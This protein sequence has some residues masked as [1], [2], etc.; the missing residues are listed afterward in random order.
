MSFS[1]G[2][3]TSPA[4]SSGTSRGGALYI[5]MILKV[6]ERLSTCRN[7]DWLRL[8]ELTRLT[9]SG[10]ITNVDLDDDATSG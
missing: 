5:G 8:G 7:S 10:G 1:L 2:S 6:Q 4:T 9:Q 3:T